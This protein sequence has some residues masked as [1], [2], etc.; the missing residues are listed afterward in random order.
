MHY[1]AQTYISPGDSNSYPPALVASILPL[2]YLPSSDLP[3]L[4]RV[5]S[6]IPTMT[7]GDNEESQEH[8]ETG[9][10][11]KMRFLM[12][13][14]LRDSKS[15]SAFPGISKGDNN[16]I[17]NR[18]SKFCGRQ[19]RADLCNGGPRAAPETLHL[20]GSECLAGCR[21]PRDGIACSP[22][23]CK[24]TETLLVVILL[25]IFYKTPCSSLF[26]KIHF[27]GL[28]TVISTQEC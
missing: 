18:K 19:T 22:C 6:Y 4:K 28:G 5:D 3:L 25:S 12:W 9:L 7:R 17:L 14:P 8:R 13:R 15:G 16:N 26:L 27:S 2:S 20:G 10:H 1:H 24:T 23:R 21:K 11:T